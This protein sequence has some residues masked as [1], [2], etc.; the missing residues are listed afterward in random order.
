M[1]SFI[2]H[3]TCPSKGP[4]KVVREVGFLFFRTEKQ[5]LMHKNL[6][7]GR[8]GKNNPFNRQNVALSHILIDQELKA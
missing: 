1:I 6:N 7:L 4:E 3:L 2:I 5:D 8:T